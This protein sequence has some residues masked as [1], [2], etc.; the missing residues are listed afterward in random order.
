MKYSLTLGN[1][2]IGL[3]NVILVLS[4]CNLF[5][6]ISAVW[7]QVNVGDYHELRHK[8][9]ARRHKRE[10]TH[11][12]NRLAAHPQVCMSLDRHGC[13]KSPRFKS[14][15][16]HCWVL[17]YLNSNATTLHISPKINFNFNLLNIECATIITMLAV[18]TLATGNHARSFL[19]YW[20]F[21]TNN[22]CMYF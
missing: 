8:D 7:F 10:A 20:L 12:A 6:L 13:F 17:V 5:N 9:V 19:F 16:D 11:H 3:T 18:N 4:S 2:F 14:T 22:L 15:S 1:P 21:N